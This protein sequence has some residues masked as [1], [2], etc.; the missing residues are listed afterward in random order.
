MP[1]RNYLIA[2]AIGIIPSIVIFTYFATKV[3]T[4]GKA[5]RNTA[6]MHTLIAAGVLWALTY[7][8]ALWDRMFGADDDAEND[9]A[10]PQAPATSTSS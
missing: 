7:A 9:D 3:L 6:I 4:G 8:P 5:A 1:F 2:T 10:L